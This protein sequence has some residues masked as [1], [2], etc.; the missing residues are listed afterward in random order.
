[1]NLYTKPQLE[2]LHRNLPAVLKGARQFLP[3][4][5]SGKR[6][7]P[8]KPDGTN[9]DYTDPQSWLSF[10]QTGELVH[11]G[12][13]FGIGLALAQPDHAETFPDWHLVTGLVALDGDAKN[14]PDTNPRDIPDHLVGCF[15][16]IASYTEY[17]T[18]LKGLRALVFGHLPIA[19]QSATHHFGDGTELSLY[20]AGWVTVSGLKVEDYPATIESREAELD[21]LFHQLMA[22]G[23]E[24]SRSSDQPPAQRPLA[25]NGGYVVDWTRSATDLVMPFLKG[26]NRTPDQADW[27]E[28]TWNAQRGWVNARGEPDQ[29]AYTNYIVR[30]ALWLRPY[31]NWDMQNVVDL[32]VTFCKL[33]GFQWSRSRAEKQIADSLAYIVNHSS[34]PAVYGGGPARRTPDGQANG[35]D[36]DEGVRDPTTTPSPLTCID[37]EI[38]Q[39]AC[40]DQEHAKS[41]CSFNN[42]AC[43][44]QPSEGDTKP[45]GN[46]ECLVSLPFVR[47]SASRDAV[48][49]ALSDVAGWTTRRAIEQRSGVAGNALTKQL[50]R[51]VSMEVAQ[52]GAD[53]RYRLRRPRK[54]RKVEPCRYKPFPVWSD[55]RLIQSI[56]RTKLVKRGWSRPLIDRLLPLAGRDFVRR[57]IKVKNWDGGFVDARFYSVERVLE[58]EHQ[59]WFEWMRAELRPRRTH[60]RGPTAEPI[61]ARAVEE[62]ET[63]AVPF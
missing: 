13:A 14:N 60:S 34:R 41:A 9:A 47:K 15:R 24:P 29:S 63:G 11:S 8:I 6:K 58:M 32:V 19:K 59:P 48:V 61:P 53:G 54:P 40:T 12:R 45:E 18:S 31:L 51:L 25:S 30:E 44:W 62:S 22:I 50:T 7:I 33:H 42:L 57:R 27:L 16:R 2:D 55:G 17:T 10:E 43:A 5:T 23:Q 38:G 37:A 21:A 39:D 46:T 36:D 1:M 4:K 52:R 35:I 56:S 26:I 28:R 49:A 3:W 20:R